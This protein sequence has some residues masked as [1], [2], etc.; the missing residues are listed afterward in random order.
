MSLSL[1]AAYLTQSA[2]HRAAAAVAMVTANWQGRAGEVV[3]V[4]VGIL[5][6]IHEVAS[7]KTN[8]GV[9]ERIQKFVLKQQN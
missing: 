5:A 6:Q 7:R 3:R 8:N 9:N 4:P 2:T 1:L